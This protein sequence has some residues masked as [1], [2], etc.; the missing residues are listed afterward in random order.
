MTRVL[1]L[2]AVVILFLSTPA[3]A[4]AAEAKPRLSSADCSTVTTY[5][6]TCSSTASTRELRPLRGRERQGFAPVRA[7][8]AIWWA[9]HP[10]SLRSG[11][12]A[13]N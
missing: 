4:A 11:R 2:L 6:A 7:I 13:C 3:I 1:I 12:A 8:R 9:L 5:T 10:G